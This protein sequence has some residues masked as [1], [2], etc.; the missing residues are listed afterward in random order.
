V[1]RES[2]HQQASAL[3]DPVKRR[4]GQVQNKTPAPV[5]IT[6]EQILLKV[7][8]RQEKEPAPPAQ[9]IADIEE[10]NDMRSVP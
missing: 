10:L 9:R 5:Q 6:S 4:I 8:E 1:P 2:Y 7:Q 3:M